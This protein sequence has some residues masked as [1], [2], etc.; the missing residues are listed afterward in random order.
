MADCNALEVV[1]ER[2]I[3]ERMDVQLTVAG[4][5][6]LIGLR[7]L[8]LAVPEAD[9]GPGNVAILNLRMVGAHVVEYQIRSRSAIHNRA[10]FLLMEI[11]A[12]G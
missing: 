9:P 3:V 6:G 7:A 8:S 4:V 11:G 5:D 10:Q 2:G 1:S 12:D